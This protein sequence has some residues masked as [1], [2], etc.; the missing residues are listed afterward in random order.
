MIGV[1]KICDTE[2]GFCWTDTHG[3]GSCSR[4]GAPYQILHYDESSIRIEK[5]VEL[6]IGEQW[7]PIILRYWNET[8]TPIPSGYSMLGSHAQ[9]YEVASP[10][11]TQQF[12]EW[13]DRQADVPKSAKKEAAE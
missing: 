13:I 6:C 11:Q 1:C 8:K 7:I 12:H 10:E 3:V 4:C 9:G 2:S 5:P